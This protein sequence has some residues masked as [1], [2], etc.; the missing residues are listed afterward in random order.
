MILPRNIF[1][2]L[3]FI[4]YQSIADDTVDHENET[5]RERVADLER[6]LHDQTDE[7]TCLRATMADALR[8]ISILEA[9]KG[10]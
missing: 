9:G 10:K 4:V 7:V 2:R 5:W 1:L 3:I 8:R 6:R